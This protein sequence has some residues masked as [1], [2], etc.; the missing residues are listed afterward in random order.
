MPTRSKGA[1]ASSG[2]SLRPDSSRAA[3]SARVS[4]S[5]LKASTTAFCVSD[6]C[7]NASLRCAPALPRRT[8]C[9]AGL[10]RRG[11]GGERG[12]AGPPRVAG[13]GELAGHGEGQREERGEEGVLL[14]RVNPRGQ[15]GPVGGD[16]H[17]AGEPQLARVL[18]EPQGE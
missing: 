16:G 9:A 17:D 3:T 11:G 2:A 18:R 6:G 15:L 4:L 14:D 8:S 12:L 7:E 13:G 5:R 1:L 10:R